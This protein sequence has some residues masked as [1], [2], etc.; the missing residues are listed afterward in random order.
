MALSLIFGVPYSEL[1]R[2]LTSA[3]FSVY[4]AWLR[5]EPPGWKLAAA[6]ITSKLGPLSPEIY[7]VST[8]ERQVDR[9][10]QDIQSAFNS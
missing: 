3:E 10:Q 8:P 4:R 5:M 2:R 1:Q 9:M 7:N 6:V